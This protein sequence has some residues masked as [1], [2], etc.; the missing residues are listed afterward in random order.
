MG[1]QVSQHIHQRG[2]R[3]VVPLFR[4]PGRGLQQEGMARWKLLVRGSAAVDLANAQQPD[5]VAQR[6]RDVED[7]VGRSTQ[8]F[9]LP[10]VKSNL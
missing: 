10:K 7:A 5:A 6:G 3:A 8:S 1:D 4:E 9:Y 2:V